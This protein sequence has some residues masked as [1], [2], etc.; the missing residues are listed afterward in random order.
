MLK[1]V[2]SIEYKILVGK[3]SHLY[4]LLYMFQHERVLLRCIGF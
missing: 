4:V 2:H 3:L 1:H